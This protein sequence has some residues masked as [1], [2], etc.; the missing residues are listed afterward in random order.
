MAAYKPYKKDFPF[1]YTLGIFPTLELLT[2]QPQ[3]AEHVFISQK[4]KSG[5]G[6][7]AIRKLC[8]Q[9]NVPLQ[10]VEHAMLQRLAHNENCFAIGVFTK[11]DATLDAK[12]SHVVLVNPDDMG[13]L[14]TIMRTMLGFGVQ[15]L[16]IITPAADVFDPKTIRASMGALFKLRIAHFTSFD[17]YA[18][19]F[20]SHHFYPFVLH[21]SQKL[22]ATTFAKP[23]SLIF[24][25][26][27]AGLPDSFAKIGT[28]ITIEQTDQIDSLNLAL[29]V[30]VALYH[31]FANG[32]E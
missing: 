23:A 1:S 21:G 24:G 6:L 5:Q 11:T 18:A 8:T 20:A 3:L 12:K 32:V 4:T 19:Q 25:N 10:E 13:N 17:D 14:G 26:E 9:H 22:A 15:D 7:A 16:A 27:G 29:S 31:H 28:T 2:A 30:G